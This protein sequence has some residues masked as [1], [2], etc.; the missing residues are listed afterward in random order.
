MA[1]GVTLTDNLPKNAGFGSASSTQGTCSFKPAKRI[2][3]CNLGNIASGATVT[4]TL[5]VKAT[6]QKPI[7]NKASVQAASPA[8]P[9]MNNNTDTKTTNVGP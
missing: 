2:V 6:D 8:D 1:N 3:T 5:T 7:I 9:N 4:V